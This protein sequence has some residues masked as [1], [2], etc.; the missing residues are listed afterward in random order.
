[1]S[2][3]FSK[4]RQMFFCN[5]PTVAA[6][7]SS[8]SSSSSSSSCGLSAQPCFLWLPPPLLTPSCLPTNIRGLDNG[9]PIKVI[10]DVI[11]GH[12]MHLEVSSRY[13]VLLVHLCVVSW[14]NRGGG[15]YLFIN[16]QNKSKTPSFLYFAFFWTSESVC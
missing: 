7:A 9:V 2:G 1:M 14:T 11:G 5:P 4:A 15:K 8:S 13:H 12:A 6:A 10:L 3:L 16:S